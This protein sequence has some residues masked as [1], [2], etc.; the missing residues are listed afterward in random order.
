[1]FSCMSNFG[2]HPWGF[3]TIVFLAIIIFLVAFVTRVFTL[4]PDTRHHIQDRVDSLEI[5]KVRLAKGDISMEE[6]ERLRSYL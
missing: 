5:L 1:M 2:G 4:R 3:G 6:F